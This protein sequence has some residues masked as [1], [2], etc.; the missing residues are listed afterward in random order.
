[1]T[2]QATPYKAPS[3]LSFLKWQVRIPISRPALYP[4]YDSIR[5]DAKH[6]LGDMGEYLVNPNLTGNDRARIAE[7]PLVAMVDVERLIGFGSTKEKAEKMAE[8]AIV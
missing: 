6:R 1:M 2:H 8:G 3:A 4:V 5:D 7:S